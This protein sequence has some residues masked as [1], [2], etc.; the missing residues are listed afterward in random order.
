MN[1]T[2]R[3]RI[4]LVIVILMLTMLSSDPVSAQQWARD[5]F[6]ETDHNFGTVARDSDTAFT[7]KFV[8]KYKETVHIKS[9]RSNCNCTIPSVVDDLVKSRE[10]SGVI[11]TF[12]T[13]AF[14][15]SRSAKITVE[16]DKPF[17]AEVELTVRGTILSDVNLEP[18]KIAFGG[19]PKGQQPIE[20]LKVSFQK[21]PN[22]KVLDVRSVSSDIMVELKGPTRSQNS[23]DYLLRVQLKSS[24]PVGDYKTQL[25]LLTNDPSLTNIAV[26][27][28]GQIRA[29]LDVKPESLHFGPLEPGGSG[30]Q[31]ITLRADQP[32]KV[33]KVTSQEKRLKFKV[34]SDKASPF[35]F[36]KVDFED[37]KQQ[38]GTFRAPVVI[39]TSLGDDLKG[40]LLIT[41]EIKAD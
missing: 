8:N 9:V 21:R 28:E 36:I 4:G 22:I 2:L 13:S 12:N 32:F 25:T 33:T 7:F 17:Y 29:A 41:G 27:V 37:D 26:P 35:H 20:E 34:L 11:A 5:M 39:E 18:N 40:S 24:A 23:V 1:Q 14:T 6:A 31:R 3:H 38:Q 19:I 30:S 15:G 16:F 10:E